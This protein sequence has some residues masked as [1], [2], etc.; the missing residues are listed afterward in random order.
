MAWKQDQSRRKELS[1]WLRQVSY[2]LTMGHFK[3]TLKE[4]INDRLNTLTQI[5]FLKDSGG[6]QG[7][8]HLIELPTSS[9]FNRCERAGHLIAL[10]KQV[11]GGGGEGE[12]GR[13][14]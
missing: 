2:N 13:R 8:T 12:D 5:Y 6:R 11:V 4:K 9:S 14:R 7:G 10:L 1:P 3:F